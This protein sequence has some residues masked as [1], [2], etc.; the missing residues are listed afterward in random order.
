[1]NRKTLTIVACLVGGLFLLFFVADKAAETLV[2][3][4]IERQIE[5][6]GVHVDLGR[7]A[8]NLPRRNVTIHNS[9]VQLQHDDT[10]V[11]EQGII[12][13]EATIDRIS[14]RGVSYNK[15]HLDAA[16]IELSTR[17]ATLALCGKRGN[18]TLVELAAMSVSVAGMETAR[19][20]IDS[21]S[22]TFG[23]ERDKNRV[24]LHRFAAEGIVVDSL[25]ASRR[26][27]IVDSVTA[28]RVVV[29]SSKNRNVPETPRVKPLLW[30]SVQRLPIALDI[31]KIV[32]DDLDITYCELA[33]DAARYGVVSI[34]DGR[35]TVANLTNIAANHGRFFVVDM[36]ATLMHSGE[37]TAQARFPVDSLDNRWTMEGRVGRSEMKAFNAA[38]EPLV[39]VRITEGVLQGMDYAI[40]GTD[41]HSHVRLTMRYDDLSVEMLKKDDHTKRRGLLSFALND[42]LIKD[43]NPA[44]N[45]KLRTGEGATDRD[46][47]R[48]TYNFFWRS[49]VPA[50]KQTAL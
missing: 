16:Q 4:Q 39:D 12:A 38:V 40:E 18:T 48:S 21:L 35:G 10:A 1:M 43:A 45:G 6:S 3:R 32:Y 13:L 42:I 9:T 22:V 20:A 5:G 2:K 46:P 41:T 44:R 15:K 33:P 31:K 17:N 25:L 27:L 14:A 50:I 49:L 29:V 7:V 23:D 24:S 36:V 26:A 8:V 37:I 30:Q 34:L 11:P 47:H 19:V 28:E